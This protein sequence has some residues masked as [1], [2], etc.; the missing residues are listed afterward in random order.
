MVTLMVARF[1]ANAKS[2][3]FNTFLTKLAFYSIGNR[4]IV[5]FNAFQAY[6]TRVW[7]E[8]SF[9]QNIFLP[10][11]SSPLLFYFLTLFPSFP[12]QTTS[13]FPFWNISFVKCMEHAKI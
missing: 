4:L 1:T 7:K 9:F 5:P 10:S 11:I 8:A 12:L 3:I 2:R 13:F 6:R